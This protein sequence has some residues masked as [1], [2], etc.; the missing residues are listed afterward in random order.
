M[1]KHR[2]RP[3]YLEALKQRDV[4][5]RELSG[6]FNTCVATKK[7]NCAG[8]TDPAQLKTCLTK[9]CP[10]G[11]TPFGLWMT[12]QGCAGQNCATVCQQ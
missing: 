12:A 5:K 3:T 2:A 11:D 6:S 9:D 7:P 8:M 4:G 10:T 1:T